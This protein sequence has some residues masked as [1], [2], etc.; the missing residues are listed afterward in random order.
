MGSREIGSMKTVVCK[1][2]GRVYSVEFPLW[3]RRF[4]GCALAND[5]MQAFTTVTDIPVGDPSVT[6]LVSLN[7]GSVRQA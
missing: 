7:Q 4:E 1:L 2:G 5:C 6:S 3:K